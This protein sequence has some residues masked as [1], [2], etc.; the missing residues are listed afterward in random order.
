M[1]LSKRL[2]LNKAGRLVRISGSAI[3]HMEQGRMDISRARMETLVAAFGYTMADYF[4]FC[5]GRVLP[6]NLRDE[7]ILLLRKCD[8]SKIH[9][10]H[11]V[12]SNLIQ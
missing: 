9:V 1:R 8:E 7:C 11:P 4:E 6:R 3:A 2:S 5:D 12:I 10:L